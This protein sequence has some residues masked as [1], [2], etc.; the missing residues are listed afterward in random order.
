MPFKII[1]FD[2]LKRK[3]MKK[4]VNILT[5]YLFLSLFLASCTHTT[6]ATKSVA[7]GNAGDVIVV[8]SDENWNAEAGDSLRS[9]FDFCPGLA[10]EEPQMDLHQIPYNK[11]VEMNQLHKN[12]I[13]FEK[14]GDQKEGSLTVEKD[15]YATNQVFVKVTAPNQAEFVKTVC[16]KRDY[17]SKLFV[18]ADRDRWI[19]TFSKNRNIVG[20]NQIADTFNISITLPAVYQVAEFLDK[21]AWIEYET[22]K[23]RNGIFV[24]EYPLTDTTKLS[25]DYIIAMRNEI[26]KVNVPGGR[27]G[28]YMTTETKFDYPVMETIMHNDCKTAVVH[29]LWKMHGDFM[30]GPFVS[31][32]KIDEARQRVVCV[33]GFVYE[34]NMPVRDKIRN[35]EGIIYTYSLK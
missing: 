17:L 4:I 26:L 19:A 5:I 2:A 6:T 22:K 24:Y 13:F 1:I 8:M 34:P 14:V 28:S 18:V 27:D 20:E 32:T 9:I 11:F 25:L 30:G 21:F 33:E 15:K 31:Y 3:H 16:E 12:I 35:I 23:A 7:H 10:Y 29:G